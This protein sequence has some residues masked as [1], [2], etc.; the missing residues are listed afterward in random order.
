MMCW[1]RPWY[2]G[3][4]YVDVELT[5]AGQRLLGYVPPPTSP[6]GAGSPRFGALKGKTTFGSA[7]AV[8]ASKAR[9]NTTPR[10]G[11]IAG[12]PLMAIRYHNGP[13]LRARGDNVHNSVTNS[14]GQSTTSPIS[15]SGGPSPKSTAI[16]AS[17]SLPGS[18][19]EI[20]PKFC[21]QNA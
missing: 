1:C 18:W 11:K 16:A 4:A 12:G 5:P 10:I 8:L 9:S 21:Q 14:H 17:L 19:V 13:A 2:R 20:F 15:K 3:H 6:R 7:A